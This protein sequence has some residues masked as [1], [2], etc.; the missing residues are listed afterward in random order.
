MA[1]PLPVPVPIALDLSLDLRVLAFTT[2]VAVWRR[3]RS[4][5]RPR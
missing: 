1:A 4:G 3:W 5:W 2:I